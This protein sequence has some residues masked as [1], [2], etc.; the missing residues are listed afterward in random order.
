ME[1]AELLGHHLKA[2]TTARLQSVTAPEE[3]DAGCA[4]RAEQGAEFV[5]ALQKGWMHV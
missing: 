1:N 5:D 2:N 4:G 3:F